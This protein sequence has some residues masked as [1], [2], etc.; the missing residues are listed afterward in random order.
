MI[1]KSIFHTIII[2]LVQELELMVNSKPKKPNQF[3]HIKI[4]FIV[5]LESCLCQK[6]IKVFNCADDCDIKIYYQDTDSTHL[7]YD[8]VPIVVKSCKENMV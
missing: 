7:D 8:D 5:V 4:V 2:T 3:Y 6:M 1:L